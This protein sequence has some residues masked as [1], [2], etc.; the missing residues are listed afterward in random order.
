M[1]ETP[2]AEIER[3][4][5]IYSETRDC[6]PPEITN[7]LVNAIVRVSETAPR[8]LTRRPPQ[9]Y[10]S[11]RQIENSLDR[12]V[13]A[14]F[15]CA[16]VARQ[17]LEDRHETGKRDAGFAP[18]RKRFMA[19]LKRAFFA[20]KLTLYVLA[21]EV[22][23]RERYKQVPSWAKKPIPLPKELL[24]RVFVEEGHGRISG[25][26]AIRPSRKLAGSD[27]LFVVLT[28]A[29]QLIVREHDFRRWFRSERRKRRW[30]SQGM[31]YA[32]P[33]RK[34]VGRPS[35]LNAALKFAI[36]KTGR[37]KGWTSAPSVTELHRLLTGQGL[38]V[39]SVD[40]LARAI[41]ALFAKTG[42]PWLG[43]RRR[44]RRR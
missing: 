10:L 8:R 43:R 25:T 32:I 6:L 35:K 7:L 34:P 22:S 13:W 28:C 16:K 36:L 41:D 27:R 42:E 4:A 21:D 39:P 38:N 3:L 30:P 44:V 11:L 33:K 20:R 23:F 29:H 40:T 31:A 24:G 37:E 2:T 12:R 19:S 17:F 15:G 18:R 1:E 26:F 14:G 9:G 5:K